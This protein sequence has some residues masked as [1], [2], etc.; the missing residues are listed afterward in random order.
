VTPQTITITLHGTSFIAAVSSASASITIT[1]AAKEG[2]KPDVDLQAD[3]RGDPAADHRDRE[4]VSRLEPRRRAGG[5]LGRERRDPPAAEDDVGRRRHQQVGGEVREQDLGLVSADAGF[6][7]L[8]V[9]DDA[10]GADRRQV[11]GVGAI[12]H[13]QR[14]EE[15][16]H[17]GPRRHR[18]RHGDQQGH[19]G[20]RARPHRREGEG[21]DEEQQRQQPGLSAGERQRPPR[22]AVEGA[23][24]FRQREEQRDA[25][26]GQEQRGREAG[27]DL[28]GLP[29]RRE[30]ADQPGEGHGRDP[31]VQLGRHRQRDGDEQ[32]DQREDGGR[33]NHA[34]AARTPEPRPVIAASSGRCRRSARS[35]R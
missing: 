29:P 7:H 25:G 33:G 26:Q 18:H 17:A 4:P 13:R 27:R 20:D 3:H 21:D 14:G 34:A 16:R 15:A 19:R 1:A 6:R 22:Q 9:G 28:L 35:R 31:D 12:G 30:G 8:R 11:A 32:G 23:V 24:G 2:G 5:R 10:D